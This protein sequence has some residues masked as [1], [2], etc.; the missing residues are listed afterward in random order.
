MIKG[1]NKMITELN[2]TMIHQIS[3]GACLCKCGGPPLEIS[4]GPMT[5]PAC[6]QQSCFNMYGT[7][8]YTCQQQGIKN[9]DPKIIA[10]IPMLDFS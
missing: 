9:L 6:C 1:E 5:T 8:K 7:N 4:M 3:G 10:T 2:N